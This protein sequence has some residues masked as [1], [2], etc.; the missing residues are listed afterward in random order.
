MSLQPDPHLVPDADPD[1]VPAWLAALRAG[2]L[3]NASAAKDAP[4]R[5]V[6]ALASAVLAKHRV[7][8]VSAGEL[9]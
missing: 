8:S 6:T 5:P 2:R 3:V 4:L 1:D 7:P 9:R